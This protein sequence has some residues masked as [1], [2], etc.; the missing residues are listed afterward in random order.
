MARTLSREPARRVC[1]P[2]EP[3]LQMTACRSPPMLK[4]CLVAVARRRRGTCTSGHAE[5]QQV[6]PR[7]RTA[8]L[9]PPQRGALADEARRGGGG[10]VRT[11]T[12][13][14]AWARS[15][16]AVVVDT[17][18]PRRVYGARSEP[19][20][21]ASGRAAALA[22]PALPLTTRH[23][24]VASAPPPVS[25]GAAQSSGE[26][27]GAFPRRSRSRSAAR[28]GCRTASASCSSWSAPT[29]RCRSPRAR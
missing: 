29:P 10:A 23:S 1:R 24:Y 3:V 17:R 26:R 6:P 25:L 28:L 13:S 11:P 20:L 14:D 12:R 9:P 18:A 21:D 4:Y 2:A 15:A 8:P 19:L 7:S 27:A 5:C 16:A 22:P